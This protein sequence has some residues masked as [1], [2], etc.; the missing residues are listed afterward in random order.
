MQTLPYGAN[1]VHQAS[2]C[3][4]ESMQHHVRMAE[5]SSVIQ[6]SVH[7]ERRIGNQNQNQHQTYGS[8]VDTDHLESHRV[9]TR[10]GR[11][12]AYKWKERV[13]QEDCSY[14][15]SER[16]KER[17]RMKTERCL[18]IKVIQRYFIV[19]YLCPNEKQVVRGLRIEAG[20]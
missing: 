19:G 5:V 16:T 8:R 10:T 1:I 9:H 11:D 13:E 17:R 2:K 14:E 6:E 4:H 7:G 12:R 3:M 18:S 20:T 15:S